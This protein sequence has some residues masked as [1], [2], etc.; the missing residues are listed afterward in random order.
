[1]TAGSRGPKELHGWRTGGAGE[2]FCAATLLRRESVPGPSRV[3]RM[4]LLA[5]CATAAFVGAGAQFPAVVF[6]TGE[7]PA[8]AYME[9]CLHLCM[10]VV[11]G[12][13]PL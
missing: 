2:L 13:Q 3:E 5:L 7:A 9:D 12:A 1:M 8:T 6:D 4:L 11:R 10:M